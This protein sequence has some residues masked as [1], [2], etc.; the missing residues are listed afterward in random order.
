MQ[1]EW[2]LAR[3]RLPLA[4]SRA[5]VL[6]SFLPS[7]RPTDRPTDR[8]SDRPTDERKSSAALS[9]TAACQWRALSNAESGARPERISA[10]LGRR[11][12]AGV[13][14]VRAPD[15][16]RG[17]TARRRAHLCEPLGWSVVARSRRAD[18]YRTSSRFDSIRFALLP[19]RL[20][21]LASSRRKRKPRAPVP[22][23]RGLRAAPMTTA[24]DAQPRKSRRRPRLAS[25]ERD[26]A[27]RRSVDAY[28]SLI[29]ERRRVT[30][31]ETW[32]R[33]RRRAIPL[34]FAPSNFRRAF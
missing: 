15:H 33:R 26:R 16:T 12:L 8:P 24:A 27:T 14:F 7:D 5:C 2:Q 30:R 1:P 19:F 32:R 11:P 6:P 25:G 9:M 17:P 21:R 10:L 3:N 22:S 29:C 23:S 20:M 18:P 4:G 34:T 28:R 13:R 31:R